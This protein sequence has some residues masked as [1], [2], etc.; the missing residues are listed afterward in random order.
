MEHSFIQSICNTLQGDEEEAQNPAD[1]QT[2]LGKEFR[3]ANFDQDCTVYQPPTHYERTRTS[4]QSQ[5]DEKIEKQEPSSNCGDVTCHCQN[6]YESYYVDALEDR[7]KKLQTRKQK[8]SSGQTERATNHVIIA[9]GTTTQIYEPSIESSEIIKDLPNNEGSNISRKNGE[10]DKY[11]FINSS[12]FKSTKLSIENCHEEIHESNCSDQHLDL[13]PYSAT[14]L[15]RN[16]ILACMVATGACSGCACNKLIKTPSQ[17]SL[18]DSKRSVTERSKKLQNVQKS[19]SQRSMDDLQDCCAPIPETAKEAVKYLYKLSD[20]ELE[21]LSNLL[22]QNAETKLLMAVKDLTK[23]SVKDLLKS[24]AKWESPTLDEMKT[25]SQKLNS[26]EKRHLFGALNLEMDRKDVSKALEALD[27]RD[28]HLAIED[29]EVVS[30]P[31]ENIIRA[32]SNLE[33]ELIANVIEHLPVASV[34]AFI[35]QTRPQ[36]RLQI[37]KA[38][39]TCAC[40]RSG[41]GGSDRCTCLQGVSAGT[42][43]TITQVLVCAP[44][45]PGP[46]RPR[47]KST[48][49]LTVPDQKGP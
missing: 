19:Y 16:H 7:L 38:L 30:I 46:G 43:D 26:L 4:S 22:P 20:I 35:H 47:P 3:Q 33:I 6:D 42:G 21:I 24:C 18:R 31:V 12:A 39:Q 14:N 48:P 27:V 10:P 41:G 28:Q 17:K 11:L 8:V 23:V 29:A 2:E 5:H 37:L 15:Q 45:R 13:C 34:I 36:K 1:L 44:N 49:D 25:A 32:L 9:A 40:G